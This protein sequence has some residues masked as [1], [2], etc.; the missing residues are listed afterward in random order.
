[1]LLTIPSAL[2]IRASEI[3]QR[4]QEELRESRTRARQI[5]DEATAVCVMSAE[6]R[7]ET[8]RLRHRARL[9]RVVHAEHLAVGVSR[10]HKGCAR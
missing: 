1:M 2:I 7:H 8:A 3:A 5:C 10:R 4:M 6:I 9:L